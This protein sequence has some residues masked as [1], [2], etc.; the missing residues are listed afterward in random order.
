[1]NRRPRS[2]EQARCVTGGARDSRASRDTLSTLGKRSVR[3]VRSAGDEG[4]ACV[5]AS[6]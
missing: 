1:M 4:E 2:Q 5:G 3:V 6:S